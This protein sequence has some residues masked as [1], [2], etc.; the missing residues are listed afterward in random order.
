MSDGKRHDAKLAWNLAHEL[1]QLF[2]PVTDAA[3]VAGSLR[4][5][6]NTVKDIEL[7]L[8]SMVVQAPAGLFGDPEDRFAQ[9]DWCEGLVTDGVVSKRLEN[10]KPHFGAKSQRLVYKGVPVDVFV[11]YSRDNL[12]VLQ[13]IRT[14]PWPFSKL[15]VTQVRKGGF[16][17]DKYFIKDGHLWRHGEHGAPPKMLAVPDEDEFFSYLKCPAMEP[18]LRGRFAEQFEQR[19]KG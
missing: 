5:G 15:C 1:V 19:R 16:L 17:F 18:H 8:L 2:G 12:G 6:A 7:V 11:T 13:T 4:R 9:L 3:M 10:G 14:G